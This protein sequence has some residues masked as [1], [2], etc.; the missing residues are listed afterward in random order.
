MQ[1][2][3][4]KD[5]YIGVARCAYDGCREI[6]RE[7]PMAVASHIH[8]MWALIEKALPAIEDEAAR[9][10]QALAPGKG[11]YFREMHDLS[12]AIHELAI[13]V[14]KTKREGADGKPSN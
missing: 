14:L 7:N 1:T 12:D 10:E 8:E 5:N 6:N 13:K 2:K 3:H 4:Y 11:A 9:R